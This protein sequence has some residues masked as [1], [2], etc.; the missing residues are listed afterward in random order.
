VA[1]GHL[2]V[3]S[4]MA[5]RHLRTRYR[6]TLGRFRDVR[7][8]SFPPEGIDGLAW[9][10][11]EAGC[12]NRGHPR[13]A[14]RRRESA[15]PMLGH[16]WNIGIR[17]PGSSGDPLYDALLRRAGP[18]RQLVGGSR[19]RRSARRPR[20]REHEDVEQFGA[21]GPGR[22]SRRALS[23]ASTSSRVTRRTLTR[24]GDPRSIDPRWLHV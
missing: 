21:S 5:G 16:P 18:L 23:P 4:A 12:P 24:G 14:T 17:T 15:R 13:G 7:G 1:F 8:A 6:E 20:G 22:A 11:G 10:G 3:G 2:V 9:K 19:T